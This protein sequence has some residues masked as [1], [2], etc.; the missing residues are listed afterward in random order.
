MRAVLQAHGY[1]F[2]RQ[3]KG[4]HEIW[5]HPN[6]AKF[7]VTRSGY[8]NFRAA[9]NWLRDLRALAKNTSIN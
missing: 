4:A 3:G 1:Q 7:T 9:K 5:V 8:G 2:H 6:G